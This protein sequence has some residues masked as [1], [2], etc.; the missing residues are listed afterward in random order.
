MLKFLLFHGK[1]FLNIP[2]LIK[3]FIIIILIFISAYVLWQLHQNNL[4][5]LSNI[6]TQ[7]GLGIK[8]LIGEVKYEL[9]E[10]EME[11][12]RKGEVAL[13]ELKDFDLEAIFVIKAMSTK[14]GKI[15]YK[16]FAVDTSTQQTSEK[17]H[18]IR[19]HMTVVPPES[20]KAQAEK[21]PLNLIPDRT[22]DKPSPK[23]RKE[24]P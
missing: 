15:E 7:G 21:K 5:P 8:D 22:I 20:Y 2:V 10:T 3:H 11:R 23:Q 16:F 19:L 1:K 4:N 9:Y 6:E 18:K 14:S 17:T 12:L 24:L 13:F